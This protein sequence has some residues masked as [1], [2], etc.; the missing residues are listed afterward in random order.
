[1]WH[2]HG[3]QP[4]LAIPIAIAIYVNIA[5]YRKNAR[6]VLYIKALAIYTVQM[7]LAPYFQIASCRPDNYT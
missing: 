2:L 1:M 5:V 6:V 4:Y 3:W 7:G